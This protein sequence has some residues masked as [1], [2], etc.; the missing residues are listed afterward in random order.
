[1][2]VTLCCVATPAAADETD[3]PLVL[4]IED[5]ERVAAQQSPGL[6]AAPASLETGF[7]RMQAATAPSATTRTPS[8]RAASHAADAASGER[9]APS[10]HE[11]YFRL[12]AIALKQAIARGEPVAFDDEAPAGGA[13]AEEEAAEEDATSRHRPGSDGPS[14]LYDRNGKLL[15][16]PAGSNCRPNR[17]SRERVADSADQVCIFGLHG[18]ILHAP[19]GRDCSAP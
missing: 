18:E 19:S 14:C 11:E 6:P 8:E 12:K 4:T 1:M 13:A 3:T 2:G 7:T 16:A 5:L 10:W 9:V 15:H 17:R